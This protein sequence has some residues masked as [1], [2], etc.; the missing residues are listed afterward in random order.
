MR[1]GGGHSDNVSQD[2]QIEIAI[3]FDPRA[4]SL[5]LPSAD[6][7]TDTFVAADVP[8]QE[9]PVTVVAEIFPS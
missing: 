7:I 6:E 4:S 1:C 5:P 9:H 8:M 2:D 3:T